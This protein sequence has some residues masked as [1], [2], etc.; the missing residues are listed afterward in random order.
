MP[1]GTPQNTPPTPAARPHQG[2]ADGAVLGAAGANFPPEFPPIA[3]SFPIEGGEPSAT[4]RCGRIAQMFFRGESLKLLLLAGIVLLGLPTP[5]ALGAGARWTNF[6][7]ASCPTDQGGAVF[8]AYG[9]WVVRLQAGPTLEFRARGEGEQ[10]KYPPALTPPEPDQP[11]GCRGNPVQVRAFEI[12]VHDKFEGASALRDAELPYSAQAIGGGRFDLAE[13]YVGDD[14][15]EHE[16]KDRLCKDARKLG[17][18]I[19]LENGLTEC[20]R[21]PFDQPMPETGTRPPEDWGRGY[22]ARPGEYTVPSG[23]PFMVLCRKIV[24]STTYLSCGVRY[25]LQPGLPFSY[26]FRRHKMPTP[27]F[28]DFV[29]LDRIL[30]AAF[31]ETVL[32]DYEWPDA[33]PPRREWL[34][35]AAQPAEGASPK[36]TYDPTSCPA[37]A[38]GM[39]YVTLGKSVLRFPAELV[40]NFELKP[41]EER[42]KYPAALTAP[43]PAAP[44]GCF[45]NPVQLNAYRV[46]YAADH[47]SGQLGLPQKIWPYPLRAIDSLFFRFET[48]ALE[49][50]V[51]DAAEQAG[52][53]CRR[54]QKNGIYR[55]LENGL[56]ECVVKPGGVAPPAKGE[57]P[58]ENWGR[59]YVGMPGGYSAPFGHPFIVHCGRGGPVPPQRCWVYSKLLPQL[60]VTY[61]IL[62]SWM[63]APGFTD[64]VAVD[65][66]IRGPLD[67]AAVENY[68]WPE[69]AEK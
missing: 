62:R 4:Q 16:I 28:T 30:R 13:N 32:R 21:R 7:P 12:Q 66:S 58:P 8:V 55:E 14:E 53:A 41:E 54:A 34:K 17:V 47:Y 51:R 2:A 63:G 19:E 18:V 3:I 11:L 65:R 20:V 67:G 39:I 52:Y 10:R 25:E 42:T 33:P 48:T 57:R 49:D 36:L 61:T 50:R 69:P 24:E 6:V 23:A 43:D 59:Y 29:A 60:A 46:T 15:Y 9:A 38:G 44:L 26:G 45:E 27:D 37:D 68:V 56:A 31:A 64:F 40:R 1:Q 22:I 35:P 5:E